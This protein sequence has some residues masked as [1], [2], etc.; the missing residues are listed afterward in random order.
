MYQILIGLHCVHSA[1]IIHRDIKPENILLNSDCELKLCDFGLARKIDFNGIQSTTNIQTMYYRAPEMLL[2][3]KTVTKEVDIWSVGCIFAELIGR[4]VFFK[5]QSPYDQFLKII[6]FCGT[7]DLDELEEVF[8]IHK[9]K[10]K[11]NC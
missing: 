7:P 3:Y 5:G 6:S 8:L 10:G 2:N 4:K 1:D 11:K 9:K